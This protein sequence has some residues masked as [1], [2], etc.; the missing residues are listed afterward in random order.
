MPRFGKNL[1]GLAMQS[2]TRR[3]SRFADLLSEPL[4]N[5][6]YKSK[7]F[8]G[9]GAKIVN[10]GELFGHPR[11]GAVDMKRVCYVRRYSGLADAGCPE[12]FS[13]RLEIEA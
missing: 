8:H 3:V 4:R 2:D 5:G 13:S 1:P 6:V 7:E 11:L 9:R 10:M 12:D